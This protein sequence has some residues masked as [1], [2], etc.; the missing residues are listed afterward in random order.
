MAVNLSE[1]TFA[2]ILCWTK[3]IDIH[4]DTGENKEVRGDGKQARAVM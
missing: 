4:G 3:C 2:L 1:S